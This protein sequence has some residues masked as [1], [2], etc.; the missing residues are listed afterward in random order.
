MVVGQ[1]EVHG[2]VAATVGAR[3]MSDG[4]HH[5]RRHSDLDVCNE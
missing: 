1:H 5:W 3:A 4:R 2:E